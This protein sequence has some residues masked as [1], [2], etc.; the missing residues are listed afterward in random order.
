VVIYS[1]SQFVIDYYKTA[2]NIWSKNK[3]TLRSGAPVANV[4]IWKEFINA[5]RKLGKPV[6]I[7][8]V[9]AHSKNIHNK[10]AD[11]LAKKSA[12]IPFNESC[13]IRTNPH[14]DSGVMRTV[15][16]ELSAQSFRSIPHSHSGVMRTLFEKLGREKNAG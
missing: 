8:K 1:D 14:S 3:W 12:K 5:K 2:E 9:R 13:K 15:I 4:P 11:K 16:P 6:E 7:K 10:R